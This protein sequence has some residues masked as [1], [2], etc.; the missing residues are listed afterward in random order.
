MKTNVLVTGS[1]GQLGLTIRE[2][3]GINDDGINFIFTTKEELDITDSENLRTFFTKTKFDY[4]INCA[5]YTNVDQAEIDFENAFKVNAEGAKN[6]AFICKSFNTI[7]IHI[8]TDY[9]F[10]GEKQKPYSERDQ[11]NP[12]NQY[13]KSKLLGE[14][15]IQSIFY[16][17]FIL[18]T[19]WLYSPYGKNFLKTIVAKIRNNA[20]LQIVNTQIGVPTST[21]LISRFVYHLIIKAIKGFGIC[22]VVP[23]GKSTWFEFAKEITHYFPNYNSNQ[24]IPIIEFPTVAIRPQYSVMSNTKAHEMDFIF[25][26]WKSYLNEAISRF[27]ELYDKY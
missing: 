12:L 24:L 27:D 15:H 8:S 25:E 17:Y 14:Q 6:L 10:D 3:Y 13:G 23:N 5:A 4:C 19:S 21:Y 1:N 16:N 7:L 11:T 22:H 2:L 9:V 20:E 26:D 18:R